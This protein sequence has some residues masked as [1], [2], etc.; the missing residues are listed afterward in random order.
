MENKKYTILLADDHSILRAGLRS[1]LSSL[2]EFDVIGE[3]DNGKDAMHSAISLKPNLL[4]TDIS[5]PKTNG[6]EAVREIKRR[7]PEV[8]ILVLTMHSSETHIFDALNSGADG[9]VLK[10]DDHNELINAINSILNGKK[11]LSPSISTNIVNGYLNPQSD[12]KHTSSWD[13]LT[14]REREIVKLIAEGYRS[15][16]IAEYLSISI[17]TVEK[18]R[19][20]LMKKL[21]LHSVSSLTNY[22]IQQGIVCT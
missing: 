15:K 2:P 3:V 14:R 6:T 13:L 11:Y 22:A 7:V 9:Y 4:I 16:D 18:H 12:A 17:K 20:N 8:K 5:M 10:E 1:M 19:T 21:D